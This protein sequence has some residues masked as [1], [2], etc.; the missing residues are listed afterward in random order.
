M[1]GP[2]L[3]DDVRI[4]AC[5][6]NSV[7]GACDGAAHQVAHTEVVEHVEHGPQGGAEIGRNHE[8]RAAS[9]CRTL[10]AKSGP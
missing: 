3:G 10:S 7:S 4:D 8:S 2:E 9:A 6:R 1:L 5:A